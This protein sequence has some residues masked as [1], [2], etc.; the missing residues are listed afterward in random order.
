MEGLKT[1]LGDLEQS[2][3]AQLAA[4]EQKAHESWVREGERRCL[5]GAAVADAAVTGAHI[6]PESSI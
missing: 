4:Q 6:Y 2:Y 5:A 3:K 1:E